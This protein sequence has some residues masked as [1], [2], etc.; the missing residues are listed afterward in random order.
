MNLDA[1]AGQSEVR[2]AFV[3]TNRNGNNIYLDNI[4]IFVSKDPEFS[5][6]AIAVHPN[7]FYL[8]KQ[9]DDQEYRLML[10]FSLPERGPVYI[11]IIDLVG[12]VLFSESSQNILNQTYIFSV[13]DLA[14]GNYFVRVSTNTETYVERVIISK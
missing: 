13:P 14:S 9:E 7:P 3:F 6:R 10:T 11:E 4:Q 12:R 8:S 2:I 1:Y 5:D